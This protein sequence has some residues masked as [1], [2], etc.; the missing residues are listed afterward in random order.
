[1]RIL[2]ITQYYYPET[3]KSTDI[4]EELAKRGHL[5]DALVGIP[6]YPE[7]KY[8]KGYGVFR[9]RHEVINGVN[10]YRC[11][12]SPRGKRASALGL[13]LNYVSFVFSAIVWVLFFFAWRKKYDAIIAHEPSPITQIIP[14]IVLGKIRNIP[15]YS[16]ILDIWPEAFISGAGIRN[17]TI[18]DILNCITR[19]VYRGSSKILIS[20][21]RFVDSVNKKGDFSDKIIYFPNWS[22]DMM[23]KGAPCELTN[24]PDG[25]IIMIAGNM[26]GAQNLDSIAKAAQEL[27]DVSE[28]K[29]VFVGDGSRRQWLEEY[30]KNNRLENV[31]FCLGR[32]PYSMMPSFY[33]YAD[34]MLVSLNEEFEDLRMVVPA[35]LQSYMSAGKPI[36]AM[37]GIGGRELVEEADCG[38][39]VGGNDYKGLADVIRKKVLPNKEFFAQKGDNGRC[40]FLEHFTKDKCI[41]NLEIIINN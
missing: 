8:Y 16:W 23:L 28:V 33:S 4:G 18:L 17:K 22:E 32:Y 35:R 24:L 29:W 34:A 37:I 27:R 11:F 9:K 36:L 38:Y 30:I 12:Q 31:V 25:F 5:V 2:I 1:M 13:S 3:F 14:A 21:R 6:N 39:A 10:I 41:S 15:V 40:Y 20:S 26:G 19:W 7:G